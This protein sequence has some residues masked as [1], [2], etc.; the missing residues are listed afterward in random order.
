MRI[1]LPLFMSIILTSCATRIP[2]P[3]TY[4]YDVYQYKLESNDYLQLQKKIKA[5]NKNPNLEIM[6]YDNYWKL[7]GSLEQ[8]S[9]FSVYKYS[10]ISCKINKNNTLTTTKAMTACNYNYSDNSLQ[11]NLT[12]TSFSKNQIYYNLKIAPT[13]ESMTQYKTNYDSSKE[14]FFFLYK[15]NV[16]NLLFIIYKNELNIPWSTYKN[17]PQHGQ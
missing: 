2:P 4:T 3:T 9:Y 8:E 5:D 14:Y 1:F 13:N 10:S 6:K 17:T 12:A 11:L 16:E 7:I 15:N